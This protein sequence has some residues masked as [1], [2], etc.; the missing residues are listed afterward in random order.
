MFLSPGM[1]SGGQET[2]VQTNLVVLILI[3]LVTSPQLTCPAQAPLSCHI[4][5]VTAPVQLNV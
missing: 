4:F 1:R 5:T 2:F 3:F